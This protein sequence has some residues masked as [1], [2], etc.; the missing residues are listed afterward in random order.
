[1]QSDTFVR[2]EF[3]DNFFFVF[4]SLSKIVWRRIRSSEIIEHFVIYRNL[5]NWLV[6]IQ[7]QR[8]YFSRTIDHGSCAQSLTRR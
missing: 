8:L 4:P 1:M 3:I 2:E 6:L 7:S 5:I